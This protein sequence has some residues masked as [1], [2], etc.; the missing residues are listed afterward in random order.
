MNHQ[1]PNQQTTETDNFYSYQEIISASA[2][3]IVI[4]NLNVHYTIDDATN[5][6]TIVT[7][8]V[9]FDNNHIESQ[10][11]WCLLVVS[12]AASIDCNCED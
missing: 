7:E 1:P 4:D 11:L 5:D 2:I 12:F 10:D 6:I 3:V 9:R 8:V